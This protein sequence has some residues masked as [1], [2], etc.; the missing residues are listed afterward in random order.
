MAVLSF[1]QF[2]FYFLIVFTVHSGPLEV[3][4]KTQTDK[5]TIKYQDYQIRIPFLGD[6][7]HRFV[8]TV[9]DPIIQFAR[10]TVNLIHLMWRCGTKSSLGVQIPLLTK[11]TTG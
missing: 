2:H 3:H 7:R 9:P 10:V 11:K 8:K 5:Q 4:Q 6:N 1:C